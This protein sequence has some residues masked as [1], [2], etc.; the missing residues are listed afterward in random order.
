VDGGVQLDLF[1]APEETSK[2]SQEMGSPGDSS[3][4]GNA[5]WSF[6]NIEEILRSVFP[7]GHPA[8]AK[9]LVE[10]ADLHSRKNRD[11]ALGGDP[12][13]NFSRVAAILRNY[14]GFPIA[15]RE[16]VAL[17]YLFKQLDAVLWALSHG[18][19]LSESVNDR[20]RDITIYSIII[21]CMLEEKP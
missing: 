8:Y 5:P 7:H 16:G 19:S 11:Y 3:L 9:F 12:L 2:T 14:P 13:G 10:D 6:K 18:H 15:S 21:R 20:L 4:L 17:V 1:L